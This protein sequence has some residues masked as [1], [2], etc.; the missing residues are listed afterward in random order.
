[1]SLSNAE[2][3][4]MLAGYKKPDN[5]KEGSDNEEDVLLKGGS[6]YTDEEFPPDP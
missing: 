6:G 4:I 2:L 3:D 1:M 5:S